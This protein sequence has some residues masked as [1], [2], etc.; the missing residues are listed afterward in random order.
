M[1]WV[2]NQIRSHDIYPF[3]DREK[4]ALHI[5]LD[6]NVPKIPIEVQSKTNFYLNIVE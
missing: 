5:S 6:V 4:E 1:F 2:S 3:V